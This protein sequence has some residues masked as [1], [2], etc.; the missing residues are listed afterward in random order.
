MDQILICS[1]RKQWNGDERKRKE[2]KG[3]DRKEKKNKLRD[4][5]DRY[6]IRNTMLVE[7][8]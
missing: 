3:K 7:A 4:D 2:R 8:H 6:E 5:S 1:V